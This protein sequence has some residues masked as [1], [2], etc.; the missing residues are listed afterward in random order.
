MHRSFRI[1]ALSVRMTEA[2]GIFPIKVF[3]AIALSTT[4]IHT[5]YEMASTIMWKCSICVS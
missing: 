4:A 3:H 1:A 5:T 2:M